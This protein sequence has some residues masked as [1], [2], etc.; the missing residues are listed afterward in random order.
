MSFA[1][2]TSWS[3]HGFAFGLELAAKVTTLLVIGLLVQHV[4]AQWRA[5]LGSTAANAC[6]IGLLL[7]PFAGAVLTDGERRLPSGRDDRDRAAV[8][9]TR[10][11]RIRQRRRFDP[12]RDFR[13]DAPIHDR[14]TVKTTRA[15]SDEQEPFKS[16]AS[17]AFAASTPTVQDGLA[18]HRAN[19]LC[20]GRYCRARPL[21]RLARGRRPTAELEHACRC[22]RVAARD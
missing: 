1:T 2:T 15:G 11:H 13:S 4:L 19:R 3:T 6:L 16:L 8:A 5:A 17:S 12:D 14:P 9:I 18:G 20:H 22:R 7:L 10:D 21:D